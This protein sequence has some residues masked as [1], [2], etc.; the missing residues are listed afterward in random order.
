MSCPWLPEEILVH[1]FASLPAVTVKEDYRIH[2]DNKI[3]LATLCSISLVSRN[4]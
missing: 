1:I 4:F 3:I 2:D